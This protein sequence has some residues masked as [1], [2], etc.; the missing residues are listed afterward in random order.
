MRTTAAA[1]I[2]ALAVGGTA[3]AQTVTRAPGA[4]SYSALVNVVMAGEV[5]LRDVCLPGVLERKPVAALAQ[6]ARLFAVPPAAGQ[7]DRVYRLASLSLVWLSEGADG[8]CS[9]YVDTGPVNELRKMAERVVLARPEGFVRGRRAL[10][11]GGRIERT[12]FCA[13]EGANRLVVSI[14]TPTKDA[15]P[16][17]RALSSTIYR[18]PGWSPLCDP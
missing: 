3:G 15:A 1:A 6:S 18:A 4:D 10:E 2:L 12:V 14:S 16:S 17:A 13:R 7:A 8:G 11:G 9:A 5:A